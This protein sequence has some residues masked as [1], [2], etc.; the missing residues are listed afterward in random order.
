MV[1]DL[2]ETH[3]E[4][5]HDTLT[6]DPVG[7]RQRCG[8]LAYASLIQGRLL[9]RERAERFHF[10]LV[11]QVRDDRPIRL[12]APQDV[13]PNQIPQR[14]VAALGVRGK[15]LIES[16][17]LR[18]R[19]EETGVDEVED[20]PQ[21]T[22]PILHRRA[23]ERDP[24]SGVELLDGPRLFRARI[25]DGLRL[26]QDRHLPVHL[27]ECRSADQGPIARED[28]IDATQ[29]VGVHPPDLCCRRDRGVR[30]ERA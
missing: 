11:W 4:G 6:L 27:G 15:A 26:V 23:R 22:D 14:S 21:I 9:T 17:E 20:R 12:E 10:G 2:L 18:A 24:R 30:D 19:A 16:P 7:G 3:E 29:S 25:L 28:E 13:R 8:Q 1:A 5:Q